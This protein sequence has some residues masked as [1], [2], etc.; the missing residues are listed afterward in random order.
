MN[1]VSKPFYWLNSQSSFRLE[2]LLLDGY[3]AVDNAVVF[4]AE[5]S[6]GANFDSE[7]YRRLLP[8]PV[9]EW[10]PY[11]TS[12]GHP[13]TDA[14]LAFHLPT[15]MDFVTC[16]VLRRNKLVDYLSELSSYD[17]LG[18]PI[19][20]KVFADPKET[21]RTAYRLLK[22]TGK[23]QGRDSLAFA[24]ALILFGIGSRPF[25]TPAYCELCYRLAITGIDRCYLHSRAKSLRTDFYGDANVQSQR[26]RTGRKVMRSLYE[27]EPRPIYPY[28]STM[29]LLQPEALADLLWTNTDLDQQALQMEISFTL[30]EAPL[31]AK[32]LPHDF[33]QFEFPV[34]IEILKKVL[35]P[36]QDGIRL[37]PDTIVHAQK[38]LVE[39]NAI[40]PTLHRKGMREKNLQ[41]IESARQFILEGFSRSE[42]AKRLGISPNY[43]TKLLQRGRV[44]KFKSSE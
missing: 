14:P 2:D 8:I 25:F 42:I 26:A 16:Q 37:W 35:D 13:M 39:E 31:V 29:P 24:K 11:L 9:A 21:V 18:L 30:S 6:R 44:N 4:R 12:T 15:L 5:K 36:E 28:P 7:V 23:R 40:S 3:D 19:I 32:K 17:D 43:L 33:L 10:A 22:S 1:F 41:L 27:K 38:W 20:T 34:Q